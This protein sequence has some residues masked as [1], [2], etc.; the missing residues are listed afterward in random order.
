MHFHFMR[1]N[2]FSLDVKYFYSIKSRD[3]FGQGRYV[4]EHGDGSVDRL[5]MEWSFPSS[6][7][8][9][10][11]LRVQ[12]IKYN[13][14]S[15]NIMYRILLHFGNHRRVRTYFGIIP[16][17]TCFR[18]SMKPILSYGQDRSNLSVKKYYHSAEFFI[19]SKAHLTVYCTLLESN[20]QK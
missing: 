4:F 18:F 8:F 14:C 7:S 11:H 20:I 9:F 15:E 17:L 3:N 6:F 13:W 10:L 19:L 2:K 16:Y 1:R 12:W 5:H